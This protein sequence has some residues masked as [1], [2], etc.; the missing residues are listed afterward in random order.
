MLKRNYHIIEKS[1]SKS[2]ECVLGRNDYLYFRYLC[3]KTKTYTTHDLKDEST[4][5]NYFQTE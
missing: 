5:V 1:L 4:K 2:I 3:M